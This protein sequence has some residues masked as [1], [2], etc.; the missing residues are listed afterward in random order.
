MLRKHGSKLTELEFLSI[1]EFVPGDHLLRIA[2]GGD[3]QS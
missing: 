1:D 3:V 2:H